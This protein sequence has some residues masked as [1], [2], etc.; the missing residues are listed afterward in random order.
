MRLTK[1]LFAILVTALL[2]PTS[3]FAYAFTVDP[4]RTFLYVNDQ[5][6]DIT[7]S[8]SVVGD[9]TDLVFFNVSV[10]PG[11]G[12]PGVTDPLALVNRA[13]ADGRISGATYDFLVDPDPPLP[14]PQLSPA[15]YLELRSNE[16]EDPTAD[17][18]VPMLFNIADGAIFDIKFM[19]LT[20]TAIGSSEVTFDIC[21]A[22]RNF[23]CAVFQSI[24][25]PIEFRGQPGNNVPEPATLWLA[26]AALI[27]GGLMFR[28]DSKPS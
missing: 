15:V 5:P 3:A 10:Q 16:A 23:E 4:S 27:A 28:K 12:F 26:A 7:F 24:A 9:A 20:S 11:T 22:G 18:I 25:V 2:T 8:V 13:A 6:A 14:D 21:A 17:P 19:G 1:L